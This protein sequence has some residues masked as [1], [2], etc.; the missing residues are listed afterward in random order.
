MFRGQERS[1]YLVA[2]G[3]S[4]LAAY[5]LAYAPA[6]SPRFRRRFALL[7]G[8]LVTAGVY[9]F[10]LLWQLPGHTAIGQWR[11]LAIAAATLLL[12]MSLA[13]AV[14]LDGW[15]VRREW[16]VCGLAA[17]NL[18]LAN[19]T[20]NLEIRSPWEA[21]ALPPEVEAMRTAVD[22][23]GDATG[24]AGRAY[25]EFRVFEDYG[26]RADVEDVWGSSPLRLSAYAK[27]FDSF[28]LDRMFRLTG[29]GHVLTWRQELFEPSKLLAE[30]P[31]QEDAT[32]L[33]RLDEPNPRLWI[34]GSAV[35]AGDEEAIALLADHAFDLDQAVVLPPDAALQSWSAD[36]TGAA[37]RASRLAPHQLKMEVG[38][39]G[40]GILV[41]G[42]NWMPGWSVR[43]IECEPACE[44]GAMHPSGLPTLRP[45]RANLAFMA[46]ALPEGDARF[47]LVYAPDSVRTG[48]LIS[49][50]TLL[51]LVVALVVRL[52]TKR[53][54]KAA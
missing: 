16:L 34:V 30:F 17:A 7:Y 41:A 29:V 38:N 53:N 15:S 48:V 11:F 40:G 25:N 8:A 35:R 45:V 51:L 28:P 26:M 46:I 1:A 50:A 20:T 9:T 2:M 31:Q 13:V 23:A 21:V 33:H 10:G 3:L 14:W 22:A 12:A 49:L 18:V 24:L 37:V 19:M 42:E 39:S 44:P 32:Y 6:A 54:R 47:T 36:Q 52:L 27:L 43:D 4:V 5:G